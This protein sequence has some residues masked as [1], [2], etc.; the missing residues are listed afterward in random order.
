MH[1]WDDATP[2]EETL[3]TMDD[4]VRSGKVNYVG[5]SNVLGWQL[6]KIASTTEK[7]G[8]NPIASLQVT[9]S[10]L[11]HTF[12]LCLAPAAHPIRALNLPCYS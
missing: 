9:S 11:M 8:I 5:V 1:V 12:Q 4:L 7:L 10:T 2:I 3:R 6:Q